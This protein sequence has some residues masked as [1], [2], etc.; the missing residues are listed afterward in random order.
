MEGPRWP[1]LAWIA[2]RFGAALSTVEGRSREG[3]WV[4]KRA[5]Y[6]A[7]LRRLED[8]E[9]L[10]K[11]A[12]H[13]VKSRTA[14]LATGLRVMQKVDEKVRGEALNARDLRSVAGALKTSQEVV[15]VALGRPAQGPTVV[16]DWTVFAKP[17]PKVV[18]ALPLAPREDP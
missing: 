13:V 4:D 7:E 3:G 2:T 11:L 8:A 9:H 10:A 16:V 15:E 6:Q 1:P 5:A 17:D 18:E 12:E 14:F